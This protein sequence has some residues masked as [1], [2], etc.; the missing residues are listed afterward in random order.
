MNRFL[1]R[2]EFGLL[3]NKLEETVFSL[4][5]RLKAIKS[6]FLYREAVLSLVSGT[7]SAVFGLFEDREKAA[8]ALADIGRT[9]RALLVETLSRERYWRRATAGV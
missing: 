4:Y 2:R 8:Q 1:A 5:P 9:E 6:S 3:E 7:G